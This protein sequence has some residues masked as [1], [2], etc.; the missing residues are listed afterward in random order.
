[1]ASRSAELKRNNQNKFLVMSILSRDAN[2][3][4]HQNLYSALVKRWESQGQSG[5]GMSDFLCNIFMTDLYRMIIYERHSFIFLE[6]LSY[7]PYYK[8][9]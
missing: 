6:N 4:E 3:A 8:L 7:C 9:S 2:K 1:M 5:S